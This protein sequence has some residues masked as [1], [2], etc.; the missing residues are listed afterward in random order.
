MIAMN[1]IADKPKEVIT[2]RC[3]TYAKFFEKAIL[4]RESEV[5][6]I[7]FKDPKTLSANGIKM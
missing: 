1:A 6:R 2:K 5:C 7:L 4:D 3:F